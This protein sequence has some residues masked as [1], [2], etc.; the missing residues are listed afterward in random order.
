MNSC[1]RCGEKMSHNYLVTI[2]RLINEKMKRVLVCI[3][4]KEILTKK[5]PV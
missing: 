1:N 3:K 5:L 2:F 4:C